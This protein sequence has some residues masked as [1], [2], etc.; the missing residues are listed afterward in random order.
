[1]ESA[2][3]AN[4]SRV[5]SLTLIV[6]LIDRVY[7]RVDHIVYMVADPRQSAG[8]PHRST[9]GRERVS[10]TVVGIPLEYGPVLVGSVAH[11]PTVHMGA[12]HNERVSI[13]DRQAVTPNF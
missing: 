1:V 7:P 4:R 3:L 2:N 9:V 13:S 12:I 5:L 11:T 8:F 6:V 10:L